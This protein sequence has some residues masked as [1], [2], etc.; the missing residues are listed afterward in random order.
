VAGE[1]KTNFNWCPLLLC[2]TDRRQEKLNQVVRLDTTYKLIMSF[3]I[4]QRY[5]FELPTNDDNL[6]V[7]GLEV[8]GYS[9]ESEEA[10]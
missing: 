7:I 9:K 6:L 8:L 10:Q 2:I 1:K 5:G 4:S 3:K